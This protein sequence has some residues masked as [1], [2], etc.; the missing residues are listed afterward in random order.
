M[1]LSVCVRVWSKC[2]QAWLLNRI[3]EMNYQQICECVVWF[4]YCIE[5]RSAVYCRRAYVVFYGFCMGTKATLLTDSLN[6][7]AIKIYSHYCQRR[8][9]FIHD[10]LLMIMIKRW[11]I[12]EQ[13]YLSFCVDATAPFFLVLLLLSWVSCQLNLGVCYTDCKKLMLLANKRMSFP[14]RN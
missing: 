13:T 14:N 6:C 1:R 12:F 5:A 8:A 2:L 7:N 11:L 9:M 3:M 4:A 10:P